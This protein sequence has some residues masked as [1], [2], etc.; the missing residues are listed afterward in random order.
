[1]LGARGGEDILGTGT[2]EEVGVGARAR[3]REAG[4]R[5]VVGAAAEGERVEADAALG[6]L[7]GGER[8]G[9]E[10]AVSGQER[11]G[12]RRGAGSER[13]G[14][15]RRRAGSERRGEER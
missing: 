4:E 1:M 9:K 3:A 11:R 15:A 10:R 6:V 8:R 12:E 7:R 2:V 5:L 13:R 14:E